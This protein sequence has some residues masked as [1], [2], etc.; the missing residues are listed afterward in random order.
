MIIVS[1]TTYILKYRELPYVYKVILHFEKQHNG[2]IKAHRRQKFLKI[3]LRI[4]IFATRT[5]KFVA[6]QSMISRTF[7]ISN[8]QIQKCS[9][10]PLQMQNVLQPG[11]KAADILSLGRLI[12]PL[13]HCIGLC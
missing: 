8:C 11:C 4:S 12:F 5:N 2:I 7:L 1:V 10:E 13:R 3:T 6:E 9:G